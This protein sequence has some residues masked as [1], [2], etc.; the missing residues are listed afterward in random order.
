MQAILL[1][2]PQGSG[3]GTQAEQIV[4]AYGIP[5][6]STGD[7]FR[8]QMQ[9]GSELGL[10]LKSYVDAG[11]L[12]PDEVTIEIVKSRLTEPDC[13]NGF[14]FDGFPR[15][16]AQALAIDALLAEMGMPFKDV[17]C[18]EIARELVVA[19]LEGRRTCETCGRIYHVKFKPSAVAGVCDVD[20]GKLLQR[21]DDT[22][23]K[24]ESRLN[25]YYAQTEPIIDYYRAQGIVSDIDSTLGIS[26]VFAKIQEVL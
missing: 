8:K 6:I 19:R 2:G 22:F 5:H 13:K 15:N 7:I 11:K 24:I 21:A 17:I 23:A 18:L 26:E 12:V 20:G 25:D 14:L 10:L 1:I 3:K 16:L 4:K 9:S